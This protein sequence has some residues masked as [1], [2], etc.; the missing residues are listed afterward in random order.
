MRL[1]GRSL[2]ALAV[3]ALLALPVGASLCPVSMGCCGPGAAAR[4]VAA[5]GPMTAKA[6]ISHCHQA[7]PASKMSC[8]SAPA[9]SE[10]PPA[11]P[12]GPAPSADLVELGASLGGVSVLAARGVA[13]AA[14]AA[15]LHD[16][17]RYTLFDALLI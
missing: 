6:P 13:P 15:R 17:G 8:C 4:V 2:A 3:L 14:H 5:A 12:T 10:A 1:D 7:R 9:T 11:A 16:L